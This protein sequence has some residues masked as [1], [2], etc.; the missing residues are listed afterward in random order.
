[1]F[2]TII[3]FY[4]KK[5]NVAYLAWESCE[6]LFFSVNKYLAEPKI[7][8]IKRQ[9]LLTSKYSGQTSCFFYWG[10][11]PLRNYWSSPSDVFLKVFSCKF[12]ASFR[13]SFS[14]NTPLEGCLFVWLSDCNCFPKF[15]R[16][17]PEGAFISSKSIC[18]NFAR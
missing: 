11:A 15:R 16:W 1:M 13:T 12:T 3:N 6:W 4:T 18:T 8:N 7:E 2:N 14:K 9:I 17:S 5:E 10:E